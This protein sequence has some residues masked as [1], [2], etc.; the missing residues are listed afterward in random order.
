MF[1]NKSADDVVASP[2]E[3]TYTTVVRPHQIKR[4]DLYN[5]GIRTVQF[6]HAEYGEIKYRGAWASVLFVTGRDTRTG[7]KV[8]YTRTS[9]DYLQVTRSG[10]VNRPVRDL[11]PTFVY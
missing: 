9:W 11:N 8:K 4:G 5:E 2:A 10:V 7:H 1:E 6:T 3:G